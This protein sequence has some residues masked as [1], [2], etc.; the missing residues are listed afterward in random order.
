MMYSVWNQHERR[1]D[2]YRSSERDDNVNAPAP[3]HLGSSDHGIPA[4]QAAWPLP[5]GAELVGR[6]DLPRGRIARRGGAP[7]GALDLDS[8][9]A[10]KI[11]GAA[12]IGYALWRWWR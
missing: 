8:S 12:A 3:K 7:L 6:G 2:Y 1:Y 9:P 4:A 10:L 11:A 5:A